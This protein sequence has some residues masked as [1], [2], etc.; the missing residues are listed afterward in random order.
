MN[1]FRDKDRIEAF[2]RWPLRSAAQSPLQCSRRPLLALK[3]AV[4]IRQTRMA[5][6]IANWKHFVSCVNRIQG[7]VNNGQ[8]S[9]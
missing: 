1:E 9:Q 8:I 4:K 3:L 5:A 7:K 6:H 2:T